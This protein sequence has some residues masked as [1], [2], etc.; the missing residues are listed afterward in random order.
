VKDVTRVARLAF[1]RPKSRNLVF[2]KVFWH[3]KVLF[4]M[5]VI[6]LH[7]LGLFDGVGMKKHC[8]AFFETSGSAAAVGLELRPFLRT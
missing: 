3:D 8:L 6:V 1:L 2:L 7:F 5:Y 4:G